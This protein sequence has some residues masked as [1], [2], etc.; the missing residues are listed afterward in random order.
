M[1]DKTELR[2]TSLM[3][4]AARNVIE[5]SKSN[6][7]AE[8]AYMSEEGV[9]AISVCEVS[10]GLAGGGSDIAEAQKNKEKS[11]AGIGAKVTRK[12]KA[13][14]VVKNGNV[15]VSSLSAE[16]GLTAKGIAS[17]IKGIIKK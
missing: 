13:I 16:K 4:E 12:P 14:I 8:N 2:L 5:I 9:F 11:P 1:Q 7:V 10:V 17:F 6:P 15:S 3:S